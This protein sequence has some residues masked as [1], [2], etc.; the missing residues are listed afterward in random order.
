MEANREESLGRRMRWLML[1]AFLSCV[2]IGAVSAG[3][4]D[5]CL[6][7]GPDVVVR[8]IFDCLSYGSVGDRAAFSLGTDACNIGDEVVN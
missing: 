3:A 7:P 8:D 4:A 6:T 2:P 1:V 5:W